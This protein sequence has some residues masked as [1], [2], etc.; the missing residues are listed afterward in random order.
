MPLYGYKGLYKRVKSNKLLLLFLLHP[1][2]LL[3]ISIAAKNYA[4]GLADLVAKV[5]RDLRLT[6]P[7]EQ[8]QLVLP[9]PSHVGSRIEIVMFFCFVITCILII[10]MDS[11]MN[12]PKPT[13]VN[14]TDTAAVDKPMTNFV[15]SNFGMCLVVGT[16]GS[17]NS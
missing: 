13:T 2:P 17:K 14:R 16:G 8:P 15:D 1:L 10:E 9:H 12:C 6:C 4:C 11:R 7:L 3:P 5:W